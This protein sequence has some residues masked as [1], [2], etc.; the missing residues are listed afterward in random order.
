MLMFSVLDQRRL[1]YTGADRGYDS[2]W[3]ASW[4]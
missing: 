2:R 4:R 1:V 3:L